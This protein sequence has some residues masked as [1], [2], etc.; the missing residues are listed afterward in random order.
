MKRA[1]ARVSASVF[2]AN[3]TDDGTHDWD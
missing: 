2:A 1:A 3:R